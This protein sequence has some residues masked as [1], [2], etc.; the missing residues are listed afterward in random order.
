M[1]DVEQRALRA[2]EHDR[3]ASRHR[4]REHQR[5]VAHHRLE[6][7]AEFPSS[8]STASHSI[9]ESWTRRLRATTLSRTFCRVPSGR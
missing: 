3:L 8:S 4:F 6:P 2:F 5:D 1:I 9:V 7:C